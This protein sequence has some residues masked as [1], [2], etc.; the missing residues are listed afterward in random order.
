[1]FRSATMFSA[2]SG[3]LVF[4]LPILPSLQ[5]R[6]QIE[7]G[8]MPGQNVGLQLQVLAEDI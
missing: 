8:K 3:A 6:L 1:M 5:C 2:I 4:S 7:K